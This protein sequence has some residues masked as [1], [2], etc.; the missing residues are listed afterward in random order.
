MSKTYE[1]VVGLMS[2][3]AAKRRQDY[4]GLINRG[5]L[6]REQSETFYNTAAFHRHGYPKTP[7]R[8]G[9]MMDYTTAKILIMGL[10]WRLVDE[11]EPT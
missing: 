9:V 7:V 2:R 1:S 10:F 8:G 4:E 11:L 3:K 6:T 5:W